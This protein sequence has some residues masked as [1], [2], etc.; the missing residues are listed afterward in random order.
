MIPLN[1]KFNIFL[2]D[3]EKNNEINKIIKL[4]EEIIEFS[5]NEKN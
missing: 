4:F 5:E 3:L 2:E 1:I